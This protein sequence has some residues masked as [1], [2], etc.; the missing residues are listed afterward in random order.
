[1]GG[2]AFGVLAATGLLTAGFAATGAVRS[3]D[4]LPVIMLTQGAAGADKCS[5][6]VLRTGAPATSDIVRDQLPDGSC[7]CIVTTGPAANNGAAENVVSDLLREREC[8][9]AP[10]ASNIGNQVGAAASTGGGGAVLPV[11]LGAVVAGGLAAGLGSS[12]NG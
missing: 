6:K 11:V 4:A 5:V 1:L 8:D 9:G 3:A 12:S 10:A 2:Y 7:I